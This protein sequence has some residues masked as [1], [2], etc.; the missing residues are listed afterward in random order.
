MQLYALARQR[1]KLADA[2]APEAADLAATATRKFDKIDLQSDTGCS[3]SYERVGGYRCA[4]VAVL[5]VNN[6]RDLVVFNP[7]RNYVTGKQAMQSTDSCG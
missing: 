3:V 7:D 5:V 6:I 4:A 2:V 1:Q